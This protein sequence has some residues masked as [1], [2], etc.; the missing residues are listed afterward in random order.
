MQG[1]M[2]IRLCGTGDGKQILRHAQDRRFAWFGFAHHK[3]L[4]M[5]VGDW[6]AFMI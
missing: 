4:S 2:A 6:I 3:P 1:R 5:T